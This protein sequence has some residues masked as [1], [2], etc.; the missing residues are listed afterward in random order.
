MKRL[1]KL[2]AMINPKVA[3]VRVESVI[4]NSY[5]NK[6]ESSGFIQNVSRKN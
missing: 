2:L 1:H 5:M 6:L 3:E 4:D